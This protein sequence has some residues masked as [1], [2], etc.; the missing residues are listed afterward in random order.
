[1]SWLSRFKPSS[2]TSGFEVVQGHGPGQGLVL[3]PRPEVL[4]NCLNLLWSMCKAL[5]AATAAV[6]PL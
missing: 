5:A 4:P 1:M 3:L 2:N 6:V